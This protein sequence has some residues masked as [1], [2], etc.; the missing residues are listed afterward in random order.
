MRLETST[1]PGFRLRGS[2]NTCR[3]GNPAT[4]RPI[5]S[6]SDR[7]P[8]TQVPATGQLLHEQSEGAF[9]GPPPRPW[10][11]CVRHGSGN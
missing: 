8:K 6:E 2:A 9:R 11:R 10:P 7:R 3:C 5:A 1:T 4:G